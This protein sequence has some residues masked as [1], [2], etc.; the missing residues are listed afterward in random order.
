MKKIKL[1]LIIFIIFLITGC[2]EKTSMENAN[3]R[4][5]SYP[6]EYV[7]KRLYGEHSDIKSIYPDNMDEDYVVSDKLITD[8]SSSNLFIFNGNEDNENDYVYKMF[9]ENKNLKII[10]ATGSLTY[11]NKIEELWLDPMNLLTIANN[12]KKGFKE[13]ISMT[14]LNNDIDKNYEKLKLELIQLEADYREVANRANNKTI[15]VGNDLFLY[16]SKYGIN[17]ISLEESDNFTKKNL[18]T[19]EELIQKGEIKYIYVKKGE[20]INKNINDLKDKYNIEI[21]ELN[22]LYTITENDRKGSNDYLTIMYNNLE[23]LKQQLYI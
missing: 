9:N 15:I 3:I 18:Y 5:S 4:V 21:I 23:L 10:D 2:Y 1:V 19:A 14:Y 20:E 7:T 8:Y 6:I 12:I 16:L 17:V 22:S 13:Y 11:T